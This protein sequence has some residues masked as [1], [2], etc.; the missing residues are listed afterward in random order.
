MMVISLSYSLH[1]HKHVQY[2]PMLV[3]SEVDLLHHVKECT[4]LLSLYEK[5]KIVKKRWNFISCAF[6]IH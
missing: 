3:L 6:W 4:C 1:L 5:E 2:F